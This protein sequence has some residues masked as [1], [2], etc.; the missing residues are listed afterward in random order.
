MFLLFI[1]SLKYYISL[2]IFENVNKIFFRRQKVLKIQLKIFRKIFFR[3]KKNKLLESCKQ[4]VLKLQNK[5]LTKSE[6]S[7]VQNNY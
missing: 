1:D 5:I 6:F 3:V 7:L 4:I 2:L